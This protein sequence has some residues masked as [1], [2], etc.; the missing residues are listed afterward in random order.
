MGVFAH[1]TCLHIPDAERGRILA[2]ALLR[3]SQPAVISTP[4][5]R[6]MNAYL[7][8]GISYK[9]VPDLPTATHLE[10]NCY[11]SEGL[12]LRLY[13]SD[14]LV[15]LFESGCGEGA[16][17]QEHLMEIAAR[18]WKE[19]H[20][21]S[22][23][24]I[25]TGRPITFWGLEEEQQQPWLL[26]AEETEEFKAFL[27]QSQADMEIPDF[28]ALVP[29][30]PQGRDVAEFECLLKATER[31]THGEPS[32]PGEIAALQ[33][34]MGRRHSECAEDYL[35]AIAKFIGLR[36][37][38]WSLPTIE[39]RLMDKIESG[40][41]KVDLLET[42]SMSNPDP[43]VEGGPEARLIE[44]GIQMPPTP[45]PVAVYIPA[46]RTG[47]LVM[48]SGQLPMVEGQFIRM[49]KVG[50]GGIPPEEAQKDARQACLN[51]LAAV[52]SV[53]G[54]LDKI[55]RIVRV[56]VY[57][58]SMDDFHGQPVVANGASR[59][60]E[61]IFGEKGKHIRSAVGVNA[62]PLDAPVEVELTVEV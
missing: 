24:D 34:W 4:Y 51:A 40:I 61:D 32:D 10:I 44:L 36:G 30:L 27:N 12:D 31:R 45:K 46:I 29:F 39:D 9:D 3:G 2:S 13:S 26:K 28:S 1:V 20:Q 17:E 18:L 53:I 11:N 58:Q 42:T 43:L 52:K 57:V 49:G 14:R 19:Q 41:I 8:L 47:N 50:D 21:Q 55:V 48:T 54:S 15:F 6:W 38:L 7:P 37:V 33:K 62:L 23:E 5:G 60:L 35:E 59:L 22:A 25:E 16:D 56:V